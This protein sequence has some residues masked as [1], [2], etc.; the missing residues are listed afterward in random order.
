MT[1][2]AGDGTHEYVLVKDPR[3]YVV[4]GALVALAAI[5]LGVW[6]FS[7]GLEHVEWRFVVPVGLLFV[8]LGWTTARNLVLNA[9]LDGRRLRVRT[10]LA[11]HD[12]PVDD[13]DEICWRVDESRIGALNP[14]N[15]LTARIRH[16]GRVL[17]LLMPGAAALLRALEAVRSPRDAARVHEFDYSALVHSLSIGPG[18]IRHATLDD[19]TLHAVTGDGQEHEVPLDTI[20]DIDDQR[21]GGDRGEVIVHHRGGDL[22]IAIPVGGELADRLLAVHAAR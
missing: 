16:R 20:E 10:A 9:T 1:G 11:H 7:E 4:I 14:L 22:R 6:E 5:G 18:T 8:A 3:P 13:I 15:Q 2:T 19:R 17:R 12:V 21:V